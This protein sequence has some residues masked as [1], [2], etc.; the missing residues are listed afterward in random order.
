MSQSVN[1]NWIE[2]D[3]LIEKSLGCYV[4]VLKDGD[5]V[6]YVGK[7]GR[8]GSGNARVLDHFREAHALRNSQREKS[9]K[10]QR[11]HEIWAR[12]E[13]VEW[14]VIKYNLSSAQSAL[15]VEAALIDF[16]GIDNLTNVQTGH[17]TS[18]GGKLSS[19][20]VYRLA[21]PPVKPEQNYEKVLLFNIE[22]SVKN[23]CRDFYEAT[24]GWWQ[25]TKRWEDATLAI[26]LIRGISFCVVED[27]KW[28]SWEEDA[29]GRRFDGAPSE[30][31]DARNGPKL[32]TR[33]GFQGTPFTE[34]GSH[35]LLNKN[36]R[37]ILKQVS[38][39]W[40][41]G[42]WIAVEF[43]DGKARILKGAGETPKSFDLG[44]LSDRARTIA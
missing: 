19:R 9:A 26:G 25:G 12:G 37:E 35:E 33:R 44:S 1:C 7:G 8:T 30:C 20:D 40:G 5:K 24:R 23:D 38:G 43:V 32:K 42:N 16:L 2:F 11:I 4:Y 29:Q 13:S 10:V 39:F 34:Q 28:S 22:K 31:S 18:S 21:A 14:E 27:L 6:F 41:F 17:G 36:F 3:A 15:D